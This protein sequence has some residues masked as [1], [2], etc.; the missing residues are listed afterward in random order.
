MTPAAVWVIGEQRQGVLNDVTLELTSEARRLAEA[1]GGGVEVV[2]FGGGD[3]VL[4]ALG[5]QGA[6]A[7][8]RVSANDLDQRN[9]RRATEGLARL[10]REEPPPLVLLGATR[11][12]SELAGRLATL[13]GVPLLSRCSRL[14]DVPGG[15]VQAERPVY[16]SRA[17]A[18]VSAAGPG[19]VLVTVLPGAFTPGRPAIGRTPDVMDVYLAPDIGG[20]PD[21]CVEASWRVSPWEMDLEEAE[22]I[23]AGGLGLA[24]PADFEMLSRLAGALGGAVGA[25]RPVVDAGI[26]PYDR[27]V[28]ISGRL[29]RPRLYVA[30]AISGSVHHVAGM[31]ESGAVIAINR[32]PHCPMMQLADVAVVGDA[33]EVVPALLA[34]LTA[35][36]CGD[37]AA[38]ALLDAADGV[39][40][41]SAT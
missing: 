1:R 41:A 3:D 8:R 11:T 33:R 14:I 19:T 37:A 15:G 5:E 30:C 23:V 7:V 34:N 32:D 40:G 35:G 26:V 22:V 20:E 39:A 9:A 28:G 21:V 10:L 25:S 27:Q 29:V 13:L 4:R 6:T 12:G 18:T 24:T 31:K 16:G 2:L 38:G 36:G 17:T